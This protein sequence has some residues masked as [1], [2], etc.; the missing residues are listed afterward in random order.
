MTVHGMFNGDIPS[1]VMGIYLI[2]GFLIFIG[3]YLG[4][5]LI[6]IYHTQCMNILRDLM[7]LSIGF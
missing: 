7:G 5:H 4:I 6:E 3:F 2:M 1:N